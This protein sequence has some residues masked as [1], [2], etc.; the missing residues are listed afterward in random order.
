MFGQQQKQHLYVDT[1]VDTEAG[2]Y[3]SATEFTPH[4]TINICPLER[5]QHKELEE[6]PEQRNESEHQPMKPRQWMESVNTNY[7]DCTTSRDP[8]GC[9]E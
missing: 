1:P 7:I 5:N 9:L 6:E 2:G 3:L 4:E 8:C